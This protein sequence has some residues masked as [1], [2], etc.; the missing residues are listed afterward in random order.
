V[1][2]IYVGTSGW[3]YDW[4]PDGF[5]WYVFSSG[6]NAVELN[7]SFYRIPYRNM[8]IGW[9]RYSREKGI[10]WSI[11]VHRRVTHVHRLRLPDALEWFNKLRN[12]VKPFEEFNLLDFYLFQLPPTFN[13]N[14]V[15]WERIADFF[16]KID[17]GWRAALE[18]R[19]KSW[20]TGE[21]VDKAREHE[22]TVVSI[23][24]PEYRFFT[25]SGPYVYLRMHGRT[26]WYAH[27]YSRGELVDV[28]RKIVSLNAEKIYVFFN[29]NHDMLDNARELLS[30][31]SKLAT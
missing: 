19:H 5:R 9:L 4:N 15:N 10:R 31:L 23:D 21:W 25:R 20:F 26:M 16:S 24:A 28:A 17:L 13:A 3:S 2:E 22:I 6:L 8:V 1:V 29:N 11:K 30:I 27:R 18:W 14:L 12:V 7:A